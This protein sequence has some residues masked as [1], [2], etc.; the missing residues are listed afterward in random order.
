MVTPPSSNDT[1]TMRI[2]AMASRSDAPGSRGGRSMTSGSG[3]SKASATPRVT[4]QT[5]LTHRICSG[6]SGSVRFAM[7]ATNMTRASLPLVGSM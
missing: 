1:T 3:S 7:T 2:P 6:V 5:M 4:A